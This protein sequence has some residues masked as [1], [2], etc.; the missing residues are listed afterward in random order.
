MREQYY[1]ALRDIVTTMSTSAAASGS[2]TARNWCFTINNPEAPLDFTE[3]TDVR[4]AVYQEESG[5]N[6]T[7]HYQGYVELKRPIRFTAIKKWKGFERAHLEQRRGTR[8]QARDYAMKEDT[9]VNG[10]WEH[11]QWVS[12]GQGARNDLENV[13]RAIISGASELDIADNHFNEWVKYRNSFTAYRRLKTGDR[14]WPMEVQ[15]FYGPPGTG[16]SLLARQENPSAYWKGRSQWWD[17]Y[18]SQEVVILDDFYGWLPWDFMLRLLDRYP[19]LVETKG[20]HV[21]FQAR[22]IVITSNSPP[23]AWYRNLQEKSQLN[24]DAIWRRLSIIRIFSVLPPHSPGSI[25]STGSSNL[26]VPEFEEIAMGHHWTSGRD[27]FLVKTA[28]H[29]N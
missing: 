26:P 28:I 11:G 29:N 8:E 19:L 1:P 17:D 9:R 6:G 2:G 18:A 24:M 20:N 4:Y 10:P 27:E 23:Q 5:E 22:K 13:R 21:K 25:S 15:F 16:K 14:D 7:R 3:L 12:G